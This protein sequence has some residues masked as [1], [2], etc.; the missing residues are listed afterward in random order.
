MV[1]I[2]YKILPKYVLNIPQ[3]N[4]TILKENSFNGVAC[5]AKIRKK[6][7]SVKIPAELV[8]IIKQVV[9][10]G[11]YGYTSVSDFVTDAVRKRLR[12]LDYLK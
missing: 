11:K 3:S 4:I 8:E 12:E 2:T 5:L 1:L 7:I 6:W 10:S 9:E